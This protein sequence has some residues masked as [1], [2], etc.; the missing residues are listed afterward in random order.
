[1]KFSIFIIFI[2]LLI[3]S[4]SCSYLKLPIKKDYWRPPIITG[5]NGLVTKFIPPM[6][7]SV[8]ENTLFTI[9]FEYEN[10]GGWDIK[11]GDYALIYDKDFISLINEDER[12]GKVFAK[13]RSIYAPAGDKFRKI[14]K[15]KTYEIPFETQT[16]SIA[17]MTC[18][19]YRTIA[20]A[21]VCVDTDIEGRLKRKPCMATNI[22]LT[23]GQ[24]APL[25]VTYIFPRFIQHE[26]PDKVTPIFE[27]QIE[28]LGGGLVLNNPRRLCRAPERK[29]IFKEDFDKFVLSAQLEGWFD[30]RC[31]ETPSLKEDKAKVFCSLPEGIS[32]TLGTYVAP[33][34]IELDYGYALVSSKTL[35][36]E[37][38]ILK[39]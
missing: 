2:S 28:N 9:A 7:S 3:F 17:I 33:L 23:G 18:W 19:N 35:V 1:M 12:F 39:E 16:T 10:V 27:I 30:L 26:D 15:A 13:G 8:F 22:S 5:T 32:K 4:T 25:A 36:I 6:P 24:G 37:K 20:E 11:D 31:T 14:I 34:K 21:N 29:E 38:A